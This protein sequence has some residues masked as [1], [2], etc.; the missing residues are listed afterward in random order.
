M[1]EWLQ[2]FPK[3]TKVV[4]LPSWERP[5]VLLP[6]GSLRSRWRGSRPYPAFKVTAR[7]FRLLVRLRATLGMV[8]KRVADG[9]WIL[10][11]LSRVGYPDL[12]TGA[13][14]VGTDGPTQKC[15]IQL[16]DLSHLPIAYLKFGKSPGAIQRIEREFSV[17]SQLPDSIGAPRALWCGTVAG[18][19]ALMI[20]AEL[21][22]P[23]GAQL[24]PPREVVD[25]LKSMPVL[26]TARLESIGWFQRLVGR[27]PQAA[28]ILELL[29]ARTWPVVPVHGDYAP[30]NILRVP[31]SPR[32]KAID[33]EY[34]AL[35]GVM[36][37]DLA[38]YV[39]QLSA[40]VFR[41]S[42]ATG[43]ER[44]IGMLVSTFQYLQAEADALVRL[45]A[46]DA[47]LSAIED[48]HAPDSML[49]VWRRQVWEGR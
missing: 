35:D 18:G 31:G 20:S 36:G 29:K 16:V 37:V 45:T 4:A 7:L 1:T 25:F 3:G 21:G 14:F 30:W 38:F 49:Q 8:E 9:D 19:T 17:L 10:E 40:L 2:F 6:F 13:V 15:I 27:E 5:K 24:P 32:V 48:G 39:L 22:T 47:Y 34:G 33:W 26:S 12:T 46:L 11:T 23:L 41:W 42:P 44:A 28:Q 43:R